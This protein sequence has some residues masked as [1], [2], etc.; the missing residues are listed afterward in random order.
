M[1]LLFLPYVSRKQ[2][3][4]TLENI[5][6]CEMAVKVVLLRLLP[7]TRGIKGYDVIDCQHGPSDARS[8]KEMSMYLQRTH[9]YPWIVF[10]YTSTATLLPDYR[11]FNRFYNIMNW[12]GSIMAYSDFY[13]I[14]NDG[15]KE[16]CRLLDLQSGSV[17]D[18][19]EFGSL[20]AFDRNEFT[21][22]CNEMDRAREVAGLYHLRLYC[23]RAGLITHIN[24]FLYADV[25]TDRRRSHEKQFDYVD[26]RNRDSQILMEKVFTNF[27][28]EI[29]AKLTPVSENVDFDMGEFPVEATV[30]IPVRNRERTIADAL[31]SVLCQQADFPFNVIVVDNHSSDN[32]SRI[33]DRYTHDPRVIHLIPDRTDLGIGGCWNY[34][35]A[36]ARCG[37]FVIQLDSDDVYS[38]NGVLQQIV[39]EF[40]KQKVVMLIGSYRLTDFN[41]NELPPGVID[42][43]EWTDTNGANNALRINGLG[44]P[45][46]FY[47]PVL[48]KFRFPNTSYGE[49]YAI[50]LRISREYRIGR[51]YDV[52]YNCRRWEGN[53]DSNLSRERVNIN[54]KYKDSL[55]TME[56]IAR[57]RKNRN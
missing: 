27:L 1:T 52:L 15:T 38:H 50:C 37:K 33:I 34:G 20:L 12:T 35:V 31:E 54:N 14:R 21:E 44:A 29:G 3:M 7:G 28:S 6:Q 26:P 46:C 19:F 16:E 17:R 13:N 55:R 18:D 10:L 23:M 8:L 30:M 42:H 49:D 9:H 32:T 5:K 25:E 2:V 45:R 4:P 24:E 57:I 48:R 47:T 56:I 39:D 43:R 51:I 22:V 41:G 11:C 36:D 40:Y 53:S